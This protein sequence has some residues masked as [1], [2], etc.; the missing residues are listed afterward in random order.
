MVL[1]HSKV[2]AL[3]KLLSKRNSLLQSNLYNTTIKSI[4]MIYFTT[5]PLYLVLLF[6]QILTRWYDYIKH[7]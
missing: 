5:K 2:Q 1:W 3:M 4:D 7:D 6:V